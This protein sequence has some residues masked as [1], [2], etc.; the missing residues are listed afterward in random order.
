MSGHVKIKKMR[1]F[2]Y[3]KFTVHLLQSHIE[4]KAV[5]NFKYLKSFRF[6]KLIKNYLFELKF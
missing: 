5:L 1:D 3:A 6:V 2:K 4:E